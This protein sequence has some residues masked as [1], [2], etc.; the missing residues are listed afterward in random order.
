[1][2][3]P[4]SRRKHSLRQRDPPDALNEKPRSGGT[5]LSSTLSFAEGCVQCYRYNSGRKPSGFTQGKND[6]VNV[7]R[8]SNEGRE[9]RELMMIFANKPANKKPAKSKEIV[10]T[11]EV[12]YQ[13][14]EGGNIKLIQSNRPPTRTLTYDWSGGIRK[15]SNKT[16]RTAVM[17][18][19][20]SHRHF[21]CKFF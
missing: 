1:M 13:D 20:H 2:Y 11:E 18:I 9:G 10:S 7:A 4:R 16:G 8:L 12:T 14:R 5:H 17:P 21:A 19:L 3:I 15:K 6:T